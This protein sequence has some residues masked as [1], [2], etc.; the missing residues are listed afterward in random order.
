MNWP[1]FITRLCLVPKSFSEMSLVFHI[2]AYDDVTA[3]E[4]FEYLNS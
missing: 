2:W 4:T 1:D 3:F